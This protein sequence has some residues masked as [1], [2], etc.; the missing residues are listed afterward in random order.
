[1]SISEHTLKLLWG[2]AASCCAICKRLL[3]EDSSPLRRT[4]LGE[5]AHIVARSPKGPRGEGPRPADMDDYDNLILLCPDDHKVIDDRPAEFSIA[6]LKERK[7]VHCAWVK[8]CLSSGRGQEDDRSVSNDQLLL[9]SFGPSSWL[10]PPNA[11]GP[12]IFIRV[13]AALPE[14]M[15]GRIEQPSETASLLEPE[16]REDVIISALDGA[17]LTRELRSLQRSWNWHGDNGWQI[18]GGAP[19]P[20]VTTAV[21]GFQWAAPRLRQPLGLRCSVL[22]GWAGSPAWRRALLVSLDLSINVLELDHKRLPADIRHYSTPVPAPGALQ[23]EELGELVSLLASEVG[24]IGTEIL[25]P[26]TGME[27]ETTGQVA[28]WI[29]HDGISLDRFVDLTGWTQLPNASSSTR[30]ETAESWP[31]AED[32]KQRGERRL[33]RKLL[34]AALQRNDYRRYRHTLDQMFGPAAD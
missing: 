11:N 28:A 21:F 9:R 8:A 17:V 34:A 19:G 20:E 5:A 30:A 24:P 32:N 6:W 7:R 16:D 25:G 33:A 3:T 4:V 31:F 27:P 23:P 29:Q 26:L 12:E 13:V 10:C 2:D 18:Q 14:S 15:P 22:T 1:M